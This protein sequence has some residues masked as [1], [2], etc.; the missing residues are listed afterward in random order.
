MPTMPGMYDP[1]SFYGY[2]KRERRAGL[3]R[4][5]LSE[6]RSRHRPSNCTPSPVSTE[7]SREIEAPLLGSYTRA[8]R[9]IKKQW[10]CSIIYHSRECG[11]AEKARL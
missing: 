5:A 2:S 3:H 6:L 7:C 10:N 4:V 1:R 8:I 11:M 9:F